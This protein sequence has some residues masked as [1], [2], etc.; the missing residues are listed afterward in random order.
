MLAILIGVPVAALIVV[1]V[2][3][4]ATGVSLRMGLMALAA[5]VCSAAAI[6]AALGFRFYNPGGIAGGAAVAAL[7]MVF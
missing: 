3:V 4:H 2:G 7:L 1:G 5:G 6:N